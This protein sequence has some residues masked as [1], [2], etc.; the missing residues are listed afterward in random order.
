MHV[1]WIAGP[2]DKEILRLRAVIAIDQSGSEF[3][4]WGDPA[5]VRSAAA[6]S[7]ADLAHRIGGGQIGVVHWG[8]TAPSEYVLPLTDVRRGYRRIKKAL[9]I[10]GCLGGTSFPSGIERAA[11]ILTAIEA[12][13]IPL[14]VVL[15][16]GF[17]IDPASVRSCLDQLPP[18]SLH[19]LL[20]DRNQCC[21]PAQE[22]GW[23]ALPLGSFTR[24]DVVDT[25][26]MAH[27]IAELVTT[28][29]GLP[30]P[31]PT[32]RPSQKGE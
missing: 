23:Q 4:Y 9:Q 29:V 1:R 3:S 5:G 15:T 26:H 2:L 27:Q 12:D 16:D 13:S 24:L 11:Q 7:V 25:D 17:E 28:A 19:V 21:T 6:I 31:P 10:P 18:A 22:A 32:R 14:V 20:V 8:S 30:A